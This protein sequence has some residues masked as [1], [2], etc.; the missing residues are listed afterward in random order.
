[1]EE[2]H[3]LGEDKYSSNEYFKYKSDEACAFE[4]LF[5]N[6]DYKN[7]TC[8]QFSYAAVEAVPLLDETQ[9]RKVIDHLEQ[10][11][12]ARRKHSIRF[13]YAPSQ[14]REGHDFWL[15]QVEHII[16]LAKHQATVLPQ[17]ELLGEHNMS[18]NESSFLSFLEDVEFLV[19]QAEALW[20][21]VATRDMHFWVASML[22]N[23]YL[24]NAKSIVYA[25]ML[26]NPSWF[27]E[28]HL[29]TSLSVHSSEYFTELQACAKGIRDLFYKTVRPMFDAKVSVDY[30]PLLTQMLLEVKELP[31]VTTVF[32][33][34]FAAIVAAS[35]ATRVDRQK[36]STQELHKCVMMQIASTETILQKHMNIYKGNAIIQEI[37]SLMKDAQKWATKCHDAISFGQIM[38]CVKIQHVLSIRLFIYDSSILQLFAYICERVRLSRGPLPKSLEVLFG[39]R[40][41]TG[42]LFLDNRPEKLEDCRRGV[43]KWSDPE[44]MLSN[45]KLTQHIF[46]KRCIPT[47]AQ[48]I[49]D[50]KGRVTHNMVE[51][52]KKTHEQLEDCLNW[53]L[54]LPDLIRLEAIVASA[55]SIITKKGLTTSQS[56]PVSWFQLRHEVLYSS[57][58]EEKLLS[59]V[60]KEWE[61]SVSKTE[62]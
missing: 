57:K 25:E 33:V 32:N 5:P 54:E 23:T 14:R 37:S 53:E 61:I 4:I 30:A 27:E 12:K 31:Q 39:D 58:L 17:I 41:I 8:R 60:I 26:L 44:A 51:Q 45:L 59:E 29:A 21:R 62:V 18:V 13:R 34:P 10:S 24:C 36:L 50:G 55:T 22:T 1:M 15:C 38:T 52:F 20:Q 11:S 56:T 40:R 47:L 35:L 3:S 9:L 19:L 28:G 42:F 2:Q 6:E 46:S 43:E 7:W 49:F 48:Q 16:S